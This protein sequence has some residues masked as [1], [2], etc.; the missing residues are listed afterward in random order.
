MMAYSISVGCAKPCGNVLMA[1]RRNLFRLARFGPFVRD[2]TMSAM[3]S[4]S[5]S[6][7]TAAGNKGTVWEAVAEVGKDQTLP[8][9][10]RKF[11]G[12]DGG[13]PV[14]PTT[15]SAKPS[16]LRSGRLKW[17]GTE[18]GEGLMSAS[19]AAVA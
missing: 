7:N 2:C 13:T 14:V 17:C 15:R 8:V 4:P 1:G 5:R 16:P 19:R 10:T 9:F 3:P 6:T 12:P 11:V 18:G